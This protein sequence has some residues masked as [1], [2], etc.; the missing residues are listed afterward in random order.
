MSA[1]MC[2]HRGLSPN[3]QR[4]GTHISVHNTGH[5]EHFISSSSSSSSNS[6]HAGW[7][8]AEMHG[9]V[10]ASELPSSSL[11]TYNRLIAAMLYMILSLSL[12]P[13]PDSQYGTLLYHSSLVIEARCP[14]YILLLY[15]PFFILV[16]CTAIELPVFFFLV[17]T[18]SM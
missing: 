18:L 9:C 15:N 10:I 1:C 14:K 16:C 5:I 7:Y 12:A 3:R 17:C 4:K 11:P 6:T 2:L 13:I 8:S